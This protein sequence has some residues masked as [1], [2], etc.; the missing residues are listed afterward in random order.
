M[1]R[2]HFWSIA[3]NTAGHALSSGDVSVYLAGTSTDATVYDAETGGSSYSSAPQVSI[4][5]DG[6]FEFWVDSTDY[7]ITQK[8][9]VTIS[10]GTASRIVDNI[11]IMRAQT[12]STFTPTTTDATTLQLGDSSDENVTHSIRFAGSPSSGYSPRI[13]YLGASGETSGSGEFSFRDQNDVL[14]HVKVGS[15]SLNDHATS[16]RYVDY[17]ANYGTDD[18]SVGS[19]SPTAANASWTSLHT[20]TASELHLV[21]LY[22]SN[23]STSAADVLVDDNSLASDLSIE[24]PAESGVYIISDFLLDGAQT[25][26]VQGADANQVFW[27]DVDKNPGG[28]ESLSGL[29]GSSFLDHAP[30]GEASTIH[31]TTALELVVL[32]AAVKDGGSGEYIEVLHDA[33]TVAR[34]DLSADEVPQVIWT[35]RVASGVE[36][37]TL[38]E[39]EVDNIVVWG[40]AKEVE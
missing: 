10:S 11:G 19:G 32:Y 7:E 16:R 29:G 18:L 34:T 22:A 14:A 24:M 20:G 1:A 31:T 23:L 33:T 26:R 5:S 2:F 28:V 38:V 13:K 39:G 40:Y 17:Y 3:R 30:S 8:F 15:P 37:K 9:K 27:A 36:V 12:E 4:G 6:F 35:G 21:T 25:L